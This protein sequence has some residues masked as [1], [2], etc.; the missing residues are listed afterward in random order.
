[1]AETQ[2]D[3]V[4][5]RASARN[6][7]VDLVRVAADGSLSKPD[8]QLDAMIS[9]HISGPN[10]RKLLREQPSIRWVAVQ[11][12][13][14]DGVMVP[15]ITNSAITVTR[16][17][18]VHDVFV[19][20]F[21][22]GLILF[23]AKRLREIV[24]A[25]EQR[26]WLTFQPPVLTGKT[27]SIVGY[28]EIGRALAERAK[29]FGMRVIGVRSRPQPD[30]LADEVWGEERTDEALRQADYAVL[31]VPGGGNRKHIFGEERLRLLG[32]EAY[33]VN[34]GRGEVLDEDALDRVLRDEGFAG[35]L[36]D[37]FE[38]EPLPKDSPLWTNPRVLVTAHLAGLRAAPLQQRVMDQIVDNIER[39]SRGEPL[40]NQV[41][42]SRGY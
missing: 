17:R 9:T 41:D 13:G 36:I 20:E 38:V 27:L 34:V 25:N 8:G 1:M 24:L 7:P 35:A 33:L 4:A 6:V 22:M 15:E 28:G 42:V 2:A 30:G 21:S 12:A 5:E 16:V 37:T 40:L 11:S 31:A 10:M 3:V 14:V 39:F 26:E 18:H 23:A 29:P 19:A 32:K